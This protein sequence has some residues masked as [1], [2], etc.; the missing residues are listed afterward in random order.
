MSLAQA[1]AFALSLATSL[2]VSIVVFRAGDGTLSVMPAEEYD[3]DA[4]EIVCEIDP[5]AR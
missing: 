2:M 4:S 5:Y 3:G 1:N